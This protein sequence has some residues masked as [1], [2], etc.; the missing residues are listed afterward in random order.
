MYNGINNILDL[1][2]QMP[3]I[4]DSA[5]IDLLM[6]KL[7]AIHILKEFGI[8][9]FILMLFIIFNFL[10]KRNL[11]KH[12]YSNKLFNEEQ[13]YTVTEDQIEIK[14]AISNALITKDKINRILYNKNV[15]YIFI[16][17]NMA[18]I[19]PESFFAD[20]NEFINFKSFMNE[21]YNIVR[22]KK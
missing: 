19:I 6:I 2:N 1:K 18:Y 4:S 7:I 5:Q 13:Y 16:A 9:F 20:S 21:N 11:R 10:F 12:Y 8:I 22:N 17:L 15:L 3:E 14:T